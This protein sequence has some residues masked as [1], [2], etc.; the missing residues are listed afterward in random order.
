M[1]AVS[2]VA[3]RCLFF[4]SL[5]SL[6]GCRQRGAG[7]AGLALPGATASEVDVEV[8]EAPFEPVFSAE[9]IPPE[10]E[11][12][13]RGKTYPEGASTSLSELRYLRLSYVD[14]D[15]LPR[16][17]EMV[18]NA[19]I[20]DDLLEIFQALYEAK[21]PICSI[22][23]VDDFGGS[24]DES[25]R[26]DNTSCFNF[27]TVP[28][29]NRLSRHALGMAVDVNPLENPYINRRGMVMPAEGQPYV[30]RSQDFP[31]KIDRDD[32]CFRLFLEHGFSWGGN[33]PAGKDYQHFEKR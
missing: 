33:W 10:V 32:L 6:A 12:R 4:V 28:G 2:A 11:A 13:M 27:R 22:R 21:Y 5:L 30:D 20:A 29:T 23:L 18:C 19:A 14:F 1:S 16:T 7:T 25:M 31:H 3:V 9:A 17:G 15:G 8:A 24:D 26:A